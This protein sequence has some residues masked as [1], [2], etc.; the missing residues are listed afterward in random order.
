MKPCRACIPPE[1]YA[2]L[3]EIAEREYWEM[4]RKALEA[5]TCD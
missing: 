2:V 5:L 4:K 3:E 1:I